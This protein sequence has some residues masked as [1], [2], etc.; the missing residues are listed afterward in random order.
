LGDL[1]V[2]YTVH[3]WLVGKRVVDFLSANWTFLLAITIEA[4]WAD[5]GRNFAVWKRVGHFERKFL[6]KG[7]S[8]PTIFGIRKLES[9]GYRMVKN[10]SENFNQLSRVHQRHRRQTDRQTTDGIAIAYSERNVVTFAKNTR[11][12]CV[13]ISRCYF[14][15]ISFW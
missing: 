12:K 3:L 14:G 1:G 4:L 13:K 5:I 6:G 7:W 10:N 9:L 15:K 8:P 11:M 2:I